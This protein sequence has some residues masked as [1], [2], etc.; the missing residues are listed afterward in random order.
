MVSFLSFPWNGSDPVSISNCRG[1]QNKEG[2]CSERLDLLAETPRWAK[3]SPSSCVLSKSQSIWGGPGRH[4][5]CTSAS[6][7][8]SWRSKLGGEVLKPATQDVPRPW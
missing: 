2:E 7:A 3:C 6:R 4:A 5:R 8:A 1:T